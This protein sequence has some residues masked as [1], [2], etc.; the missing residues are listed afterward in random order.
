MP[1]LD[2]KAVY[3]Q[4]ESIMTCCDKRQRV[5]GK[6]QCAFYGIDQDGRAGSIGVRAPAAAT[7]AVRALVEA[8]IISLIL[9]R[10]RNPEN[11]REKCDITAHM[12]SDYDARVSTHRVTSTGLITAA[13]RRSMLKSPSNVLDYQRVMLKMRAALIEC[14]A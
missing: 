5:N 12:L 3:Q 9:H 13:N 7:A 10:V 2:E 6:H 1:Y 14:V 8:A 11:E 4:E